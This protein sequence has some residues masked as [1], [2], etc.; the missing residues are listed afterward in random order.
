MLIIPLVGLKW[1]MLIPSG[2]FGV[3]MG[4][5]IPTI[6]TLLAGS[7]PMQ[8]RAA[9]M[10][11]NGSV[12]RLGQTLGPVSTGMVYVVAGMSGAFYTGAASALIIIVL[13][14]FLAKKFAD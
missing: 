3:A 6:Q 5:N 11:V 8:Y 14:I 13:L 2:I 10:S 4:I 9:F 7:A 12:L 1:F